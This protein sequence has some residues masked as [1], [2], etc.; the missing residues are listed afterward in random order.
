MSRLLLGVLV[1]LLA[2]A[3]ACAPESGDEPGVVAFDSVRNELPAG[4]AE[5]VVASGRIGA[6]NSTEQKTDF[7]V[8]DAVGVPNLKP[9]LERWIACLDDGGEVLD[10][11]GEEGMGIGRLIEGD[12]VSA[13]EW[14]VFEYGD[15]VLARSFKL[16]DPG[17]RDYWVLQVTG[18]DVT[19][20]SCV[21]SRG[22]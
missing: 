17:D 15:S 3:A 21:F 11:G 5:L 6:A 7:F 20:D 13:T 19:R 4:L 8:I 22:A 10:I 16:D 9:D 2:V 18:F 1:V 14:A 12:L